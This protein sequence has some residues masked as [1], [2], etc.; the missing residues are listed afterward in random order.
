MRLTTMSLLMIPLATACEQDAEWTVEGLTLARDDLNYAEVSGTV[1]L[2]SEGD[3]FGTDAE[4]RYYS[5][6]YETLIVKAEDIIGFDIEA[7]GESQLFQITHYEV[8]VEPAYG[9]FDGVCAEF[10]AD[11]SNHTDW[12]RLGCL[13]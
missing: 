12:T 5:D 13:D 10:R 1:T 4:V 3:M 9:G 8:Y 7:E 11:N 6:Q 2:E